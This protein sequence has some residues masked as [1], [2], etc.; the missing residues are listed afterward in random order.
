MTLS[1]VSNPYEYL[2]P[3][4]MAWVTS[5]RQKSA[6]DNFLTR[7]QY[8]AS[9]WSSSCSFGWFRH[10]M[11]EILLGIRRSI[12]RHAAKLAFQAGFIEN[13]Q[14]AETFVSFVVEKQHLSAV[15]AFSAVKLLIRICFLDCAL[16]L[17]R[18]CNSP[19][20]CDVFYPVWP[21]HL[22]KRLDFLLRAADFDHN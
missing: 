11:P 12:M 17:S 16:F 20:S 13:A 10:F 14:Q 18:H 2:A 9:N 22:D 15:S 3:P 19:C 1:G 8:R 4:F 7:I 5:C 6:I 21:A